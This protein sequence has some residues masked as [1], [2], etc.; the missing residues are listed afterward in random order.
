MTL[1]TSF[2][3]EISLPTGDNCMHCP[4]MPTPHEG[5]APLWTMPVQYSHA[6]ESF[7]AQPITTLLSG[8]LRALCC[9]HSLFKCTFYKIDT[10]MKP[11]YSPTVGRGV[12]CDL[13]ELLLN[14]LK[15]KEDHVE[16]SSR[17][18]CFSRLYLHSRVSHSHTFM[19]N[20]NLQEVPSTPTQSPF[21]PVLKMDILGVA[22]GHPPMACQP[23]FHNG[24]NTMA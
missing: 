2:K 3:A 18:T 16:T 24:S 17:S 1:Q 12:Q 22:R 9:L 14:S 6:C 7:C 21:L 4:V 20:T 23:L 10:K 5:T 19:R 8:S 13:C 15:D 11:E